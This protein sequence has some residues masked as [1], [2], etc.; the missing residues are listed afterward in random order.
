MQQPCFVG[1]S[2]GSSFEPSFESSGSIEGEG[3]GMWVMGLYEMG[4]GELNQ[5][6]EGGVVGGGHFF[7]ELSHIFHQKSQKWNF[8][9]QKDDFS[10]F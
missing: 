5:C 10:I 6:R 7:K 3:E 2:F 1:S 9:R 4:R 8:A